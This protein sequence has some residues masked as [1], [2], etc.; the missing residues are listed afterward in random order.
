MTIPHCIAWAAAG[1]LALAPGAAIPADVPQSG[2]GADS[3]VPSGLTATA[4]ALAL[5]DRTRAR[6]AN[7]NRAR[8][9]KPK[10]RAR[11]DAKPTINHNADRNRNRN[12]RDRNRDRNND[13]RYT[14]VSNNNVNV[15]VNRNVRYDDYDH[16]HHDHWDD[17][18]DDWHPWA[19]AAAVTMTAAVIGS[20][21]ASI[22]PDCSTVIVN[23]ISYSQCGNTWYQPQYYGSSVQYV[24]VNPP[25]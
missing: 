12:A 9:S 22:P 8:P 4:S 11:H 16:R 19:T 25:R 2:L 17:W 6:P 24:V 18:D 23:G 10:A 5:Q 13:N 1:T 14:N 21:V 3:A 7:A 15:N 20:I